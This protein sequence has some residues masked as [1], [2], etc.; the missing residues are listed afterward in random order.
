[1]VGGAAEGTEQDPLER[2]QYL[3]FPVDDFFSGVRRAAA[4]LF[5]VA[6]L[7]VF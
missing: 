2:L 1:M 3:E 7:K 4:V 5:Q 6:P